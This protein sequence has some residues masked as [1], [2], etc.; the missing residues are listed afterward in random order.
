MWVNAALVQH[1]LRLLPVKLPHVRVNKLSF[2]GSWGDM[3]CGMRTLSNSVLSF[4]GS[5]LLGCLLELVLIWICV[6]RVGPTGHNVDWSW[7]YSCLVL[8]L[9]MDR[10]D[11][12][13]FSLTFGHLRAASYS[14][15]HR[16]VH[17]AS[18]AHLPVHAELVLTSFSSSWTVR[19]TSIVGNNAPSDDAESTR[20]LA[21]P[22]LVLVLVTWS[23]SRRKRHS[24]RA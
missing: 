23:R 14:P 21:L 4:D 6:R 10:V 17:H 16:I 9:N 11:G 20:V 24:L 3:P 8:D 2:F 7:T 15:V 12:V 19:R 18:F 13:A 22:C 5:K 1:C